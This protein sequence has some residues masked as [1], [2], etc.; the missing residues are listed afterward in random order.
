MELALPL[1]GDLLMN[2]L[3]SL[4][5]LSCALIALSFVGCSKR[6]TP[7]T[8]QEN[9]LLSA[10]LLKKLPSSTAFFSVVDLNSSG[11]KLLQASPF[12]SKM[13]AKDSL[14]AFIS[15]VEEQG[16]ED[17]AVVLIR[18]AYESL[19]K[20]GLVSDSGMYSPEKVFSSVVL[21]A[22]PSSDQSLPVDV[23]VF[24]D[25][26]SNIDLT[27][28]LKIFSS[29]LS[30]SGLQVSPETVNGATGLSISKAQ[31][32][33]K[34]YAAA[35][36]DRFGISL[37]KSN[38]EGLFASNDTQTLATLKALPEFKTAT[39][40]LASGADSLA[41]AFASV[42]RLQPLLEKLASA[43]TTGDLDPKT[44][45]VI[46][47]AGSTAF[48]QQYNSRVNVVFAPRND[49]QTKVLSALE[50]SSLPAVSAKLP[51]DTAI[52]LSFDSK[53][54]SKIEPLLETLKE[55]SGDD[56]SSHAKNI[57]G[58]TL[59]IRNNTSGSPMPDLY[60]SIDSADRAGLASFVESSLGMVMS[61]SGQNATWV[62]K[63]ISESPTRYFTT[64][65]GVGAYI[66]SPKGSS[67]LLVGTSEGAIRDLIA[68]ESGKSPTFTTSLS[69]P[70]QTQL[71]GLNLVSLYLN[72]KQVAT[73][74]DSVKSSLAMFTGG[75]PELNEALN[76]DKIRSLG[77]GVGGISY[78]GG[79]LSLESSFDLS[80]TR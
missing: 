7:G 77:V 2:K 38:L 66:S 9:P 67:S 49:S 50:G 15:R 33:A 16:M 34:L 56:I 23:G 65:I 25:H 47:F 74:V 12:G 1:R 51:A 3:R 29:F 58:V 32:P 46:A 76:P 36:K 35:N 55:Q 53:F 27:E 59:G 54:I 24:A 78:G 52:A 21:F 72:F 28:K 37:A 41:F 43:E 75:N 73:I 62:S 44:I 63:D 57:H 42:A 22:G 79:V 10:S 71:N 17:D 68:S 11:Y 80:A 61:L 4:I 70:L 13:N 48:S 6:E 19:V 60:L 5:T 30:E 31:V 20:I 40:K 18:H 8:S 26:A 64:L 39:A 69:S 14:D 45:P